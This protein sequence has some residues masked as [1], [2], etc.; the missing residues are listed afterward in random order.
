M[1][2]YIQMSKIGKK[3]KKLKKQYK[4]DRKIGM[5]LPIKCSNCGVEVGKEI[6]DMKKPWEY[7]CKM[8][9]E[10][11]FKELYDRISTNEK[12]NLGEEI[13]KIEDNT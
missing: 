4:A 8:C 7:K 13:E 3:L 11:A 9:G 5:T 2:G 1:G 12:F 6:Y 10:Y